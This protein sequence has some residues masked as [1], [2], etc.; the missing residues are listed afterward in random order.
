MRVEHLRISTCKINSKKLVREQE[1][2][3][4]IN[5]KEKKYQKIIIHHFLINI[6][7]KEKNVYFKVQLIF[8]YTE[9]NI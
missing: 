4:R 8:I 7:R 6:K 2:R 5:P 9:E 3:K 1:G